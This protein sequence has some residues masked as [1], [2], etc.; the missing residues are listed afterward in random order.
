MPQLHSS[1]NHARPATVRESAEYAS[2][3]RIFGIETEYGVSVTG[4]DAPLEG[5]NVAM[6][7]FEPVMRRYRS[8][9][10]FVDNGSRLYV[11]VGAHPE[12][13]TAEARSSYDALCSDLAGER[14]MRGL[15][16]DA[17]ERLRA[18]HGEA[19]RVHVFKN[20]VDSAGHSFGCH[21]NYLVRRF[22]PLDTIRAVLLPFLISRQLFTGAGR[23][24]DGR[25][26]YT[27]R[28]SFVNETISSATTRARPMVNTR[29]EPHA[30]PDEYR[31]LHVI[32]GDSNRSQ[33]AT[34][35]KLATT[36]VV[37]SMMEEAQR[38]SLDMEELSHM[39]LADAVASNM[40]V[41]EDG[42][43]AVMELACGGSISALDMQRRYYAYAREF[44]RGHERALASS[45]PDA[46]HPLSWVMGQWGRVLD[47]LGENDV[48]AL[49]PYVDWAAKTVW[50]RR[51]QRR[52]PLNEARLVQL[53]MDYHDVAN[54]SLYP[55][56]ERHGAMARLAR[57]EDVDRAEHVPPADT[58]AALRGAFVNATTQ[59][60]L[61]HDCDWTRLTLMEPVR[62][63]CELLDPFSATPTSAYE[64]LMARIAS[65]SRD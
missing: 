27:Q 38:G 39:A 50:L 21:E 10:T 18:E 62:M 11:D 28:A 52:H 24:A 44:V 9:N 42:A 3:D 20:N 53:D 16:L 32:I 2:F 55:S 5:A 57:P 25:M 41:N 12:Y 29:D 8:T 49:A 4:A 31:R 48:D 64:E 63:G 35:M 40:R 56:L 61:R 59:A 65:A 46:L 6:A 19:L 36:H 17:Q 23:Y 14:I 51:L 47:L 58:R 15:A 54:G 22:V 37:L 7:M 13:A 43:A 30:N 26:Y 60:G 33:W 34:Y 1:A 45:W